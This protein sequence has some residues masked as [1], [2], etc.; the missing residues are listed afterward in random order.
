MKIL[1]D[2]V[3]NPMQQ[4][5][6]GSATKLAPGVTIA[7]F[8]GAH[9][10]RTNL[11]H[12][13]NP[14]SREQIARNLYLH[15]EALR[16]IN[17]DDTHFNTVRVVVSEGIYEGHITES[18]DIRDQKRDGRLVYYEV[19]GRDGKIDFEKTFDV[20][21][22]WKDYINFDELKLE[23]DTINPD[24]SLHASIG[25]LMPTVPES[26]EVKFKNDVTTHF[27]N[28]LQSRGELVEIL[29]SDD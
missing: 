18:G 20:A 6:I 13:V 7:K 26:Y 17:N 27:N 29:E 24:E 10:D 4:T 5:A 12:I 21:E 25:L 23:Y 28:K 1:V 22:Y 9:G 2:P 14:Q 11:N 8:L 16:T 19:I 3:Y 15:A